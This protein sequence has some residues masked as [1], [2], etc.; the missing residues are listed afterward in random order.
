[1]GAARQILQR[2]RKDLHCRCGKVHEYAERSDGDFPLG[3]CPLWAN[4]HKQWHIR[5]CYAQVQSAFFVSIR[6]CLLLIPPSP[7]KITHFTTRNSP[8]NAS[9][10]D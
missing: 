6:S 7:R 4:P 8:T 1:M 5:L 9:S 2:V 10:E 3:I